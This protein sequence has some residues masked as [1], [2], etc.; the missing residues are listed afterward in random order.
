MHQP[1]RGF[2]ATPINDMLLATSLV[3]RALNTLIEHDLRR[4]FPNTSPWRAKPEEQAQFCPCVIEVVPEEQ[5]VN[6]KFNFHGRPRVL[7]MRLQAD[8]DQQSASAHSLSLSLPYDY[9]YGDVVMKTALQAL[10]LLGLVYVSAPDDSSES[11]SLWDIPSHSMLDATVTGSMHLEQVE[12]LHAKGRLAQALGR[13]PFELLGLDAQQ[14]AELQSIQDLYARWDHCLD[15]LMRLRPYLSHDPYV[16][17]G[18]PQ[19]VPA[20]TA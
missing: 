6:F 10:R 17:I 20:K 3:H 2:V 7:T 12:S 8:E 1:I 15:R 4:T 16:S 14:W 18:L 11:P 5:E 9:R 13:E 19:L